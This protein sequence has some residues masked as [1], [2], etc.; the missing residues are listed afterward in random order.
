MAAPEFFARRGPPPAPLTDRDTILVADFVNRTGDPDF[1]GTLRQGLMAHL[2]QSPFLA[3]VSDASIADTLKLMK[4]RADTPVLGAIAHEACQRTGAKASVEGTIARIGAAYAVTLEAVNCET[5]DLLAMKQGQADAKERVLATLGSLTIAFRLALGEAA[6]TVRRPGVPLEQVTTSSLA[7]LKAFSIANAARSQGMLEADVRPL[8]QRAVEIDPTF[9]M[10]QASLAAV[11]SNIGDGPAAREHATK[12]YALR[13]RISEYEQFF[14]TYMHHLLV[15]RDQAAL[16]Q[17]LEQGLAA[18]PRN[19]EFLNGLAVYNALAGE[20]ERSLL[21]AERCV[22]LDP[23]SWRYL[24]NLVSVSQALGEPEKLYGAAERLIAVV[25]DSVSGHGARVYAAAQTGDAARVSTFR[26]AAARA[27]PEEQLIVIDKNVALIRGQLGTYDKLNDRYLTV[28]S[29]KGDSAGV[30]RLAAV[31]EALNVN[32]DRPLP[33]ALGSASMAK[34]A[35]WHLWELAWAYAFRG[36]AVMAGKLADEQDRRHAPGLEPPKPFAAGLARAAAFF[37]A[38]RFRESLA[39][40]DRAAETAGTQPAIF[41]FRGRVRQAQGDLLGAR[42]DYQAALK[43]R[44]VNPY[45]LSAAITLPQTQ[46]LAADLAHQLGDDVEARR[47]YD[48]LLHQWKDADANFPL[49][50][51]MRDGLAKLHK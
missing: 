31:I 23:R 37:A 44:Y 48:D 10:A 42:G 38:D 50:V 13:Y 26:D 21:L 15:T 32:L 43:R 16:K 3:A 45:P 41:A 9:A 12:A 5:G 51:Q 4:Q 35:E 11:F 30:A 22:E 39:L 34:L 40:L 24:Q 25:P 2:Q 6:A 49:L 29:Q 8:M 1:D 14:V 36:D 27:I 46:I 20:H 17:T 19:G 18:F 28:L 7:A 33:T 47:L